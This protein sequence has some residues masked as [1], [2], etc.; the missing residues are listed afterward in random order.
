MICSN[1]IAVSG[2]FWLSP[3]FLLITQ[4]EVNDQL[5][6]GIVSMQQN[7]H[8]L[9]KGCL[10][11]R[12]EGKQGA[13]GEWEKRE[14]KVDRCDGLMT[15]KTFS[16]KY[17]TDWI[18]WMSKQQ[19]NNFKYSWIFTSHLANGLKGIFAP[20]LWTMDLWNVREKKLLSFVTMIIPADL[21]GV[22]NGLFSLMSKRTRNGKLPPSVCH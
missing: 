17:A 21:R 13:S 8:T 1:L 9:E 2:Y 12:G 15:F 3:A 18:I 5:N 19:G 22:L 20:C 4:S 16:S 7:H 11:G 6:V 14:M 10:R